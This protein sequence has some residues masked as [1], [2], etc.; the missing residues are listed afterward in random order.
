MSRASTSFLILGST[1]KSTGIRTCSPGCSVC[2]VKQKHWILVK[3]L[4]AC[5]G[6]TLKVAVPVTG[7]DDSFLAMKLAM[8]GAPLLTVSRGCSGQNFHGSLADTL[9][10]KHTES[11]PPRPYGPAHS[12]TGS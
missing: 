3:Y 10:S 2:W 7:C 5:N 1:K 6:V 12:A 4:P 9:E 11:G 8:S